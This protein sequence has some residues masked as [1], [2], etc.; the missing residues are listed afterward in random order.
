M[1]KRS[2]LGT[3]S[4]L[5]EDPAQNR[6]DPTEEQIRRLQSIETSARQ[7][8]FGPVIRPGSPAVQFLPL[9]TVAEVRHRQVHPPNG[10]PISQVDLIDCN[11]KPRKNLQ[12]RAIVT[13]Q[14]RSIQG[15]SYSS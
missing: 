10:Y 4:P 1:G 12:K 2:D 11:P 9:G 3:G 13:Q 15:K 7:E 8:V 5:S 6:M 14:G